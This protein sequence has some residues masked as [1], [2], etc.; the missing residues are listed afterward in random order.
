M[1]K[2]V[3]VLFGGFYDPGYRSEYRASLSRS[4]LGRYRRLIARY[5]ND[6]WIF[7]TQEYKWRQIEFKESERKPSY[8]S[9]QIQVRSC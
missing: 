1:W 6:T 4:K 2:H 7:D 5:L 9:F 3:I 8:V